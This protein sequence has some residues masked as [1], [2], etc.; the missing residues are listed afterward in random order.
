MAGAC[1]PL[2]HQSGRAVLF[3]TMSAHTTTTKR[4]GRA[5]AARPPT[6]Q[7]LVNAVE[8]GFEALGKSQQTYTKCPD[9]W[10]KLI[11]SGRHK[12]PDWLA[13]KA[14]AKILYWHRPTQK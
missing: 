3:N 14:M 5:Q 8:D 13:M 6:A 10:G 11:T 9:F 7:Q 1:H 12:S 2:E 4:P